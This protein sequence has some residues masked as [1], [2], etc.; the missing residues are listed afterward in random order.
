LDEVAKIE[1]YLVE[2]QPPPDQEAYDESLAELQYHKREFGNIMPRILGYAFVTMLYSE[3]ELQF[4]RLCSELEVK[5]ALPRSLDKHK[6]MLK[7]TKTT[8]NGFVPLV[9]S[10]FRALSLPLMTDAELKTLA[11]LALL[12][13]TIVHSG[14]I[15][16]DNGPSQEI[17][18]LSGRVDGIRCAYEY[19]S[20]PLKA[21]HR[22]VAGSERL[23][24]DVTYCINRLQTIVAIFNRLFDELGMVTETVLPQ[25]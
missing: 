9:Q 12:R 22:V 17:K 20:A 8:T 25:R 19:D 7:A 15:I 13:N 10:Y 24:I 16:A 21:D 2:S 14:G 18:E 5:R 1:R 6:G 4:K 3:T 23:S 11:E